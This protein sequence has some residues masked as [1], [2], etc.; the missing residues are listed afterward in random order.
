MNQ[1]QEPISI[2]V[3]ESALQQKQKTYSRRD[4]PVV[5]DL[6]TNLPIRG[7]IQD[8]RTGIHALLCL[9]PYVITHEDNSLYNGRMGLEGASK[10]LTEPV[11]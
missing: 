4:S 6:S 9:W 7:L 3:T 1:T 10:T 8:E 5:T 2:K 11:L